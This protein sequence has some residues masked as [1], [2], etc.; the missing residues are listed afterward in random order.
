MVFRGW[1]KVK[2]VSGCLMGIGFYY[3]VMRLFWD[4]IEVVFAQNVNATK[5]YT[6]K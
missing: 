3:G 6:L 5:L 4:K 2:I 1:G